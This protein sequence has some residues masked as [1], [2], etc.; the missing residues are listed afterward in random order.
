VQ[1]IG[2]EVSGEPENLTREIEKLNP[3]AALIIYS[4]F[5]SPAKSCKSH[6]LASAMACIGTIHPFR[7]FYINQ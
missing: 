2:I 6:L 1:V 5:F 3:P 4:P 7:I